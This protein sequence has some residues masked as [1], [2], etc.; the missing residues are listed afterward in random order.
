MRQEYDV[1]RKEVR[2]STKSRFSTVDL[3]IASG[4]SHTL[5]HQN[6]AGGQC[7]YPG[8]GIA[9]QAPCDLG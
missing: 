3:Y 4:C 5:E 6:Q 1:S 7:R 9:S 8:L 2:S